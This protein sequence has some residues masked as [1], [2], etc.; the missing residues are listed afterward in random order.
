MKITIFAL[1]KFIARMAELV[2]ALVSKTSE[3]TLVPVRSRLR[4]RKRRLLVLLATF[5]LCFRIALFYI[6]R[7]TFGC[8][9]RISMKKLLYFTDFH[10]LIFILALLWYAVTAWYSKGYYHADEHYQIIE[11]AGAKLGTNSASEQAWEF[12]AASRQTIQP[13]MAY[14]IFSVLGFF[15]ISDPYTKSFILRLLT[16]VI[17]LLVIRFFVRTMLSSILERYRNIFIFLSYFLWFVPAVNVRFSSETW[18]GLMFLLAVAMLHTHRIQER[19]RY[20]IFG[21]IAGFGFLF[22]FQTA[23]LFLG[24]IIWLLVIQRITMKNILHIAFAGLLV[25]LAGVLIDFWF[26]GRFV[27]TTWEYFRMQ[28]VEDVASEF[29][30]EVWYFYL[31]K[32]FIAPFWPFGILTAVSLFLVLI[33]NPR[34]WLVWSILPFLIVHSIIPHKEV[35]FLL[36]LVNLLPFLLVFGLQNLDRF[37]FKPIVSRLIKPLQLAILVLFIVLNFIALAAMSL[38]PSGNGKMEISQ[39]IAESYQEKPLR[40][41]HC[42]WSSPYNPFESV[43]TKFYQRNNVEEIWITSLCQLNDSL[44]SDSK[45]NLLVLRQIELKS[46]RCQQILNNYNTVELKRSIPVWIENLNAFYGEMNTDDIL[47]L[48]SMN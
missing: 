33:R 39:F 26:Y 45:E 19:Y 18:S 6:N 46:Q 32:L 41:I 12:E 5:F 23:F 31:K 48:Y 21:V 7:L 29:G 2:D 14:V 37:K 44:L 9:L 10:T 11:F 15:H 28:I 20:Y 16:T 24:L 36:P 40:L 8:P 35:R 13:A 30:T 34:N 38:K 17:A 4:V 25:Q 27:L 22:R 3:V 47:V 1:P 43:P 42:S